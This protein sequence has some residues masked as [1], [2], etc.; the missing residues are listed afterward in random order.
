LDGDSF[1][2]AVED[3]NN[4]VTG[5]QT[6]IIDENGFTQYGWYVRTNG[7]MPPI[8]PTTISSNN[9][10]YRNRGTHDYSIARGTVTNGTL[11]NGL[12]IANAGMGYQYYSGASGSCDPPD[13]DN[14]A[15]LEL[16]NLVERVGRSWQLQGHPNLITSMDMSRAGGGPWIGQ[17]GCSGHSQHQNGLEVDI[18]YIR[19]DN[20]SGPRDIMQQPALYS[21]SRTQQVVDMF[22][23]LATGAGVTIISGD[24]QLLGTVYDNSGQH[25]NHLHIWIADPDGP[26]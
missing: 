2:D 9:L 11:H 19:S 5:M 1:S 4:G 7:D 14:W 17:P 25:D 18:R 22:L 10:L 23:R 12:R 24:Q 8:V 16:I 26:N 13:S 21:R 3:E 6:P 15:T 20:S